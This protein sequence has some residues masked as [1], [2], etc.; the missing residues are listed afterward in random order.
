MNMYTDYLWLLTDCKC[1]LKENCIIVNWSDKMS[2]KLQISRSEISVLLESDFTF[3]LWEQVTIGSCCIIFEEIW[4]CG[5]G[6][7]MKYRSTDVLTFVHP[8]L[9]GK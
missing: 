7:N 4:I 2:A 6:I 8:Q 9:P 5:A 3:I 1:C